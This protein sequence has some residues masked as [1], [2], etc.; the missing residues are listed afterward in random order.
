[1]RRIRMGKRVDTHVDC[2]KVQ[3][4]YSLRCMPQVHGAARDAFAFARRTL[5]I[6]CNSAT[7]NPLVFVDNEEI[8][9]GGNF[10]GQPISLALDVVA[11]GCTQLSSIGHPVI[12]DRK[13]GD[14]PFNR[15]A[16]ARWG[17]DRL[18]LHAR[19]IARV[20]CRGFRPLGR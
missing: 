17:L 7:D 5:E 8:V 19:R 2:G 18:F 13:Y 3:D 20:P 9:S 10:H 12:G 6:E 14:F 1:M 11:M 4:P 15:E 16:K